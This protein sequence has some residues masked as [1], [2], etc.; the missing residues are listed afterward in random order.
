MK[1]LLNIPLA[2]ATVSLLA[3]TGV[4]AHNH[5]VPEHKFWVG[6]SILK[7]NADS[8]RPN[9]LNFYD[10]GFGVGL[11][12][13]LFINEKWSTRLDIMHTD[14]ELYD[15]AP[16]RRIKANHAALDFLYRLDDNGMYAFTGIRHT[17]P[18]YN[19]EDNYRS[20]GLGLGKYWE[21]TSAVD[22]VT[23]IATHHDFEND[24]DDFTAKLGFV[25]KFGTNTPK[26]MDSD[27]DGVMDGVDKCPSSPRGSSVDSLGCP[28]DNDHDGIVNTL[29]KCPAT[30]RGD[31]VDSEGCSMMKLQEL[32]VDLLVLFA[33]D[34]AVI[35]APDSQDFVEFANFL[36]RFGNTAAVIEGHTSS[37]GSAAYNMTLSQQ[38]AEAVKQLLVEQYGVDAT[39][40]SA[41]GY[42]ET[43]LKNPANTAAAHREN[44]RIESLVTAKV[45]VKM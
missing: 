36:K 28:V 2:L 26:V 35:E 43:R 30:P 45:T 1:K 14:S 6:G 29:D 40:I 25:M 20:V 16:L 37:V 33:N 21:I 34:S 23:E 19:Q 12:A 18:K 7:Y 41:V 8:A 39:R 13:G 38:R 31:K 4:Q 11:E 42:G 5:S 17:N 24:G 32:E 22:L 44:R 9:D 15:S 27:G 3:S 10:E